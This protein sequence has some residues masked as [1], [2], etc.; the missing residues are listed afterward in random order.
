MKKLRQKLSKLAGWTGRV[1]KEKAKAVLEQKV[2][3]GAERA[4]KEYAE[5]FQR[6]AEYDRS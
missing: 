3:A 5:V 2:K 6:L 4:I 1:S